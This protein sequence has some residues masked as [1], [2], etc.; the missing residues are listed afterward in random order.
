MLRTVATAPQL[1]AWFPNEGDLAVEWAAAE[2]WVRARTRW[3]Q[4]EVLSDGSVV[5]LDPPADLVEAVRILTSRYLA[6]RNS[7]VGV[8]G[9]DDMGAVRLPGSDRDVDSLIAPWRLVV[10][11]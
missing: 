10:F 7:P 9:M 8:V 4:V 1:A 3:P 11:G 5:E 2:A 6:R